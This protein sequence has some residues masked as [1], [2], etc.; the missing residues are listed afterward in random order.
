MIPAAAYRRTLLA[1]AM[2]L[3]C[4]EPLGAQQLLDAPSI[5]GGRTTR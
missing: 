5:A 2:S 1:L 3:G 4:S